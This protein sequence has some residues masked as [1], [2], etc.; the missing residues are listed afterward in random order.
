[1][2][3]SQILGDIQDGVGNVQVSAENKVLT[4]QKESTFNVPSSNLNKS[5]LEK[6]NT[7]VS[8]LTVKNTIYPLNKVDLKI[9][10]E[11]FTMLPDDHKVEQAKLTSFPS[12]MNKNILEGV[13]NNV[14]DKMP[15]EIL[16]VFRDIAEQ[17]RNNADAITNVVEGVK[18]YGEFCKGAIDRF[19]NSRPLVIA[20]RQSV[21]LFQEDLY[22]CSYIN[23]A[24]LDYAKYSGVLS[25]MFRKLAEDP[26]LSTYLTYRSNPEEGA[27]ISRYPEISLYG[28]C[29]KI[30]HLMDVLESERNH[31]VNYVGSLDTALNDE[32][33][34]VTANSSYLVNNANGVIDSLNFFKMLHDILE[35]DDQFFEKTKKLL[36]F[37]D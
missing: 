33:K 36:E 25:E 35:Q 18:V 20:D 30:V 32:V 21:D 26:T 2:S 14:A 15:D 11:V 5:V 34:A 7:L 8:T 17:I 4:Q 12:T 16:A 19:L 29:D 3:L 31:L 37:L 27:A 10:Q 13:L 24:E 9:A 1:M 22:R 6:F 28:L 23:D